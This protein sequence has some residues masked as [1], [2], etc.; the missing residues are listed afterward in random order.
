MEHLPQKFTDKLTVHAQHVFSRAVALAHAHNVPAVSPEHLLS[1]IYAEKGSLGHNVLKLNNVR[2]PTIKSTALPAQS[3]NTPLSPAVKDIVKKAASAAAFYGHNWIGTEHLLL[4]IMRSTLALKKHRAYH[5]IA[6][7]LEHILESTSRL[8][9]TPRERRESSRRTSQK[10]ET[11]TV[12]KSDARR[13]PA[14]SF[15]CDDLTSRAKE[16][17]LAPFSGRER[18]LER[19][20]STLLRKTKSNPLLVG[21]AGVG[22]TAL[23]H[24]LAQKIV[25]HDAP[26]ELTGMHIFS[27]DVGLL[28]AGTMFRGEFEARLKDVIEEAKEKDVILFIDE[29]H[30]IVGAGSASGSL[31]FANILKPALASGEIRLIAATTPE[32]YRQSIE[33]SHALARRFQPIIVNEETEER[34]FQLLTIARS[35]YESHHHVSI[36]DSA[37]KTAIRLTQRYQPHR[38]LPDK[39]FDLIDETAARL[40]MKALPATRSER[41]QVERDLARIQKEKQAS[42]QQGDYETGLQLKDEER[43]LLERWE[44]LRTKTGTAESPLLPLTEQHIT[45]T[46]ADMLSVATLDDHTRFA[47]VGGYL[48]TR[49]IGQKEALST[50]N[51]TMARAQA[52][53]TTAERPIASFLFLGPSGVGK[54]ETAKALAQA[55]FGATASYKQNFGNFIRFDMSEFTEP[56]S[57]SRLIGA[58]PGYVGY[59]EGGQLVKKIKQN[60]YALVLF[61]EIE[62]AHPQIFNILL[63]LLD[64]GMLTSADGEHVSFKHAIVILT[65]N[66]GTEEFNKKALGFRD[67]EVNREKLSSE[68]GAIRVRVLAALKD[69]LRPELLN[70]IDHI[71]TFM[72]LDQ[73]ALAQIVRAHI[74]ELTV[75][76][77]SE[78]QIKLTVDEKALF[79]IAERSVSENEGARLVKRTIAQLVEYPLAQLIVNGSLTS[80]TTARVKGIQGRVDISVSKR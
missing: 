14:L 5:K 13:F 43:T 8:R 34:T 71:I 37:L 24:G 28:V 63:Q 66:I 27:L 52:G 60:P 3:A 11:G 65:S 21:E 47:D 64:E 53:L 42:V 41:I 75:K 49:I 73:A 48:Q 39:A 17:T 30:V 35:A 50:I 40:R 59:D 54:T 20:V 18:E 76:L 1:A 69:T 4:G 31:D 45:E 44:M 16:G 70:R 33:K 61:D 55:V 79:L 51:E 62:K 67:T 38:R 19:V 77:A 23:V 25:G 72:P 10:G 29:I 36:A 32:E 78:K 74:N 12:K 7:Q 56:H 6:H 22:K 58:P 15:F 26:P 46:L 80:G 57:I 68:Y 9:A 2:I